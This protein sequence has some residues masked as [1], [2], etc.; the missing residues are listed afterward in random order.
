MDTE[1]SYRIGLSE[2]STKLGYNSLKTFWR[3]VESIQG[4]ISEMEN[5]GFRKGQKELTP[6]QMK[7]ICDKIGYPE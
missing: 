6:K 7:L 3:R 1:K 2:L 5:L 4:L